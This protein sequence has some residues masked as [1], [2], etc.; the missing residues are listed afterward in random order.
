MPSMPDG[1]PAK[2]AGSPSRQKGIAPKRSKVTESRLAAYRCLEEI[3]VK[4]AFAS[5]VIA[6]IIDASAMPKADKAFATNLVLGVIGYLGTLD[7]VIDRSLNS[8]HDI[9]A[10]VRDAIRISTYEILYLEKESY[11]ACDQGVELVFEIAPKAKGLA[12]AVL[13]KII[14][15]SALFPFGDIAQ[16]LKAYSLYMGYPYW[17]VEKVRHEHGDA[18]A[19]DFFKASNEVAPLFISINSIKAESDAVLDKLG[20]WGYSV[21]PVS[22]LGRMIPGCYE[23]EQRSIVGDKRFLD[24]VRHGLVLISDASAQ[25]IAD[26]AC[27]FIEGKVSNGTSFEDISFLELCSG[28]ATK[29][30]LLQS[31]INRIFGSQIENM[32]CLDNVESKTHVLTER[33]KRYNVD[34]SR[35]YTADATDLEAVFADGLFDFIFLDA[36]CSGLGTLRRHP[37][38]RWRITPE[39]IVENALLDGL[40]L[41]QASKLLK[42]DGFIVYSTCTISKE[43]NIDVIKKFLSKN[44]GAFT[45]EKL[46]DGIAYFPAMVT[47]GPDCHFCVVIR[48]IA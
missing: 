22:V 8:L 1:R 21:K 27:T 30:I 13:R 10:N 14:Q 20:K 36:P 18:W 41:E 4:D 37:E 11:A 5:S 47:G 46:G 44:K 29:T 33:L 45:I 17:L 16:N 32:V 2:G 19:K 34:I 6:R 24:L 31:G 12:N 35:A 15:A 26:I 48:R 7:Y 42:V 39:K 9:K 3:R 40:I 43:E 38:I 23:I 28:R 25:A